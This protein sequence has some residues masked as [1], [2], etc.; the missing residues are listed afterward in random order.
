MK[1]AIR[2][3][4]SYEIGGGHLMRCLTL[5]EEILSRGGEVTLLSAELNEAKLGSLADSLSLKKISGPVGSLDDANQTRVFSQEYDWLIIDGYRFDTPY[6]EAIGGVKTMVIDDTSPLPSYPTEILLN[7]NPSAV[8]EWYGGKDVQS[9]L[10]GIPYMLLRSDLRKSTRPEFRENVVSIGIVM[11][12]ADPTNVT[13]KILRAIRTLPE[14]YEWSVVVGPF[15]RHLP[16]LQEETTN[17]PQ[18]VELLVSPPMTEFYSSVDLVV[19]AGGST[20]WELAYL[21]VP[22]L[23]FVIADNQKPSAEMAHRL[24]L[25]V[26]SGELE[27]LSEADI[28]QAISRLANDREARMSLHQTGQKLVDG[29]GVSR[30]VDALERF[31]YES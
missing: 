15:N 9:M 14:M 19:T 12:A 17:H 13:Q 8:S 21:G 1:V 23:S 10:L 18:T 7:N 22:N 25:T 26:N 30:V 2:V 4:A 3:D 11:G 29:L 27:R 6:L 31:S 20:L 28:S 24:G 16:S 5:A